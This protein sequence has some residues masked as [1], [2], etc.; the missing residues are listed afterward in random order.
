MASCGKCGV[1][2]EDG[3]A[4]CPSCIEAANAGAAV[5]NDAEDNKLMAVLAYII[6]FIPLLTGA[7]KTSPFVKFH[8]NQGTV[9]WIACLA[10][11]I[12]SSI[13]GAIVW[14]LGALLNLVSIVFV[15]FVVM[16]II[17]ALNGQT[18]PL[19]IIGEITILK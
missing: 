7:Y 12:I 14:F 13:I 18:K 6:F 8:T 19:P 10:W 3:K 2:V 5:G 11:N 15:V 9:L 17:N 4:L 1:E 16:G